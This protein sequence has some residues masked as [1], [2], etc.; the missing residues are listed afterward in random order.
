MPVPELTYR[1]IG[2]LMR[3]GRSPAM[4]VVGPKPRQLQAEGN[5]TSSIARARDFRRLNRS[6]GGDQAACSIVI[7]SLDI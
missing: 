2:G 5:A 4:N 7:P 6:E 1:E 3:R